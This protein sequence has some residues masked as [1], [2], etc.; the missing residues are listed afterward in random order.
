M[1][2]DRTRTAALLAAAVLL[3]GCGA[4]G[5]TPAEKSSA[6]AS[7]SKSTAALADKVFLHAARGLYPDP[8]PGVDVP[9][10]EIKIGRNLCIALDNGGTYTSEIT[11]LTD[12]GST[13]EQAGKMLGAAVAV[14]CPSHAGMSTSTP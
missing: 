11:L 10:A 7:A 5:P 12:H 1:S 2:T 4:S 9:A 14:Y 13:P 6:S 8:N 3:A